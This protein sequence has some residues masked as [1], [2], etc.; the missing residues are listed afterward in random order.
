MSA[1]DPAAAAKLRHVV[2][3]STASIEA[4]CAGPGLCTIAYMRMGKYTAR[5]Q[6]AVEPISPI[7]APLLGQDDCGGKGS[8]RRGRAH[9]SY[10]KVLRVCHRANLPYMVA[11]HMHACI[12]QQGRVR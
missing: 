6:K 2:N 3:T 10:E 4:R 5:G 12:Q 9:S 1:I 7:K 11:Q 8:N